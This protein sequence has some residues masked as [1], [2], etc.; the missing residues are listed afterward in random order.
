VNPT[1]LLTRKLPPMFEVMSGQV[2]RGSRTILNDVRFELAAGDVLFVVGPNGAGKS[3][4]IDVCLGLEAASDAVIAYAGRDL[5][6]IPYSDRPREVALVGREEPD[7]LGLTVREVLSLTSAG[8]WDLGVATGNEGSSEFFIPPEFLER[9]LGSLSQGE[10]QKVHILRGFLQGAAVLFWDEA[11][12][13]LDLRHREQALAAACSYASKGHAV[14]ICVHEIE[15]ALRYASRVLVL[16]AGR[17]VALGPPRISFSPEVI[18]GVFGLHASLV[19]AEGE[20]R[21]HW[22]SKSWQKSP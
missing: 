4:L 12:A 16:D 9:K 15:L 17:S 5:R 19:E 3:T 13:H 2:R 14:V 18:S 1:R 22:E 10:R 21:L 7:A 11:T 8:P 6:N 20:L